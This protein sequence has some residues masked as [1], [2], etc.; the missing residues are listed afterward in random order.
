MHTTPG[1]DDPGRKNMIMRTLTD[2]R[3][4]RDALRSELGDI[5]KATDNLKI[6][7]RDQRTRVEDLNEQI[8][9][10]TEVIRQTEELDA[11]TKEA[12]GG[13]I[14]PNGD[15]SVGPNGWD[16]T[17]GFSASGAGITERDAFASAILKAGWNLRSQPIIQIPLKAAFPVVDTWA[18]VRSADIRPLGRDE[19]YLWPLLPRTDIGNGTAI[20]DFR[21][22]GNRTVT[23]DIERDVDATTD[24]AT[25]DVDFDHDVQPVKTLAIMIE[26]IPNALLT[27]LPASREFFQVEARHAIEQALDVH[28]YDQIIAAGPPSGIT[29]A[30][31]VE[32]VRHGIAAMRA[33]GSN[34]DVLVVNPDDAADLDLFKQPGT[35]DY[36]FMSRS[37]GPGGPLWGLRVVERTSATM[38][39]APL[40]IDSRRVGMLYLG[41]LAMLADPYSKMRKNLVDLRFE[42]NGLMHIRDANA[43]Y[44]IAAGG[45]D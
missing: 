44:L 28:V 42:L 29:G 23:G 31:L 43:A 3:L 40:L 7:T 18:P 27:S 41:V 37:G 21:Q 13:S 20:E 32:Q 39:E 8:S 35:E 5:F 34:P 1:G 26:D 19:R 45:G 36:A 22:T 11:M 24:K 16:T 4:Q 9:D 33:L 14:V 12:S 17:R 15:G 38:D 10:L 6:S 25:L 30:N 2:M